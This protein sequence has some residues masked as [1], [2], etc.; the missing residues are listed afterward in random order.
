MP[1]TNIL[2][3]ITVPYLGAPDPRGVV[4]GVMEDGEASP[5]VDWNAV[6]NFWCMGQ[7]KHE[8]IM[9]VD[10]SKV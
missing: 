3:G 10:I 7:F 6:G 2:L 1:P 9:N 5:D 4:L 8:A